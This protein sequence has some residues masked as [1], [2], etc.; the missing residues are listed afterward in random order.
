MLEREVKRLLPQKPALRAVK[1]IREVNDIRKDLP[2]W[3]SLRWYANMGEL[4]VKRPFNRHLTCTEN[5]LNAETRYPHEVVQVE[6]FAAS[7]N[8]V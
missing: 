1:R 3:K 4:F 7:P 5:T 2:V 6:S 8:G